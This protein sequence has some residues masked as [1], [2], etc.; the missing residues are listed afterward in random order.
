MTLRLTPAQAR[1]LIA[2]DR[3]VAATDTRTRARRR[4]AQ[5]ELP[6]PRRLRIG[7]VDCYLIAPMPKPR[8]TRSDRWN[9]S[10][11]VRRYRAYADVL[12]L[13]RLE[14]PERYHALYVLTAPVSAGIVAELRPHRKR[15]DWDN[16]SKGLQDIAASIAAAGDV[17]GAKPDDSHHWDGRGT[18]A[19]GP[20]SMVL[21]TSLRD[22]EDTLARLVAAYPKA[23]VAAKGNAEATQSYFRGLRLSPD[24]ALDS[25]DPAPPVP[26][27]EQEAHS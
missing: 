11:A 4:S 27:L 19:Y 2:R 17:R 25:A 12:R 1:R 22:G 14:L 21:V 3:A 23:V 10:P 8:Q 20:L 18:K 16:L 24:S 13:L 7:D 15:G 5:I 9:P 26:P 6:T